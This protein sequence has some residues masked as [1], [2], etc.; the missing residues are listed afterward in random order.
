MVMLTQEE[1]DFEHC[2]CCG[3]YFEPVRR[4]RPPK[5]PDPMPLFE[6]PSLESEETNG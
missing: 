6:Q 3:A 5:K 1:I 2:G 4:G